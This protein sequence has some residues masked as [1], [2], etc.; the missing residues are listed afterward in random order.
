MF[1]EK[2]IRQVKGGLLGIKQGTKSPQEVF[3]KLNILKRYNQYMFEELL[4]QYKNI[5]NEK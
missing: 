5:I 3:G 2:L 1:E 4:I